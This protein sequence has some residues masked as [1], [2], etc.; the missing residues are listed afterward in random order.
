MKEVWIESTIRD[1][2][3]RIEARGGSSVNLVLGGIIEVDG[4]RIEVFHISSAPG[5][6]GCMWEGAVVGGATARPATEEDIESLLTLLVEVAK[7]TK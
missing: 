5:L 3:G 4:M 2:Y 7:E 6:P 1:M